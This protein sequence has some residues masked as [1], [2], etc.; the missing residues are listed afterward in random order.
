VLPDYAPE[1]LL[2]SG[3]D[4]QQTQRHGVSDGHRPVAPERLWCARAARHNP[5]GGRL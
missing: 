2:R 3:R 4:L 1:E 5:P